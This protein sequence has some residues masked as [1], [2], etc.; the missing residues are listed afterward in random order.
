MW[1]ELRT[2]LQTEMHTSSFDGV[3]LQCIYYFSPKLLNRL[4]FFLNGCTKNAI[5]DF[6]IISSLK[7]WYGNNFNWLRMT[8][9]ELSSQSQLVIEVKFRLEFNRSSINYIV[10]CFQLFEFSAT[11]WK[12]LK[13]FFRRFAASAKETDGK[14]S[15]Q[16]K[17]NES[18]KRRA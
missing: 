5:V 1:N 4:I 15:K 12:Y 17:E 14:L 11:L 2:Q 10:W 8:H 3:V 18:G 13:H 9:D 6:L 16:A 7:H